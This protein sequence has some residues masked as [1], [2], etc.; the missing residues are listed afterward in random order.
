M[1]LDHLV[2]VRLGAELT[3]KSKRTRSAFLRR[4]RKNL[5][6]A[7]DS[8]NS[9]YKLE[10]EWSR[11]YVRSASPEALSVLPRV[12]GV[13]SISPIELVVPAAVDDI[14]AQASL[15]RSEER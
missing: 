3:I 5:R 11:V 15:T 9:P 8:T 4:L 14:V 13:S 7:L 2:L 6:S 12:F 1:A 10:G